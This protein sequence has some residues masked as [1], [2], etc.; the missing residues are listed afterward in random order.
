MTMNLDVSV[1]L[2][3][4]LSRPGRDATAALER[5]GATASRLASRFSP[6]ATGLRGL[7]SAVRDLAAADRALNA[8]AGSTARLRGTMAALGPAGR[9]AASGMAPAI[10]AFDKLALSSTKAANATTRLHGALGAA[11]PAS[12]FVAGAEAQ[13]QTLLASQRAAIANMRTLTAGGGGGG[14]GRGGRRGMGSGSGHGGGAIPGLMLGLQPSGR[15]TLRSV[16]EQATGLQDAIAKMHLNGLSD[17]EI[18]RVRAKAEEVAAMNKSTTPLANIGAIMEARLALGG[19]LNEAISTAGEMSKLRTIV[20]FSLGKDRAKA[21]ED[22]VYDM[23]RTAEVRNVV[24]DPARRDALFKGMTAALIASNGRI[25]PKQWHST[26]IYGRSATQGLSDEFQNYRLPFLMQEL[27]NGG[28]GG[29]AGTALQALFRAIP[30]A[31]QKVSNIPEWRKLGM[32]DE[33]KVI[34]GK[35]GEDKGL[36]PSAI[37]GSELEGTDPD[38]FVY[39]LMDNMAKIG[40]KERGPIIQEFAHLVGTGTGQ[41]AVDVLGLQRARMDNFER[42]LKQVE[43]TA[44]LF[45]QI[46]ETAS[47]SVV[48]LHAQMDALK[49]NIGS[50]VIPA[51]TGMVDAA[52][53][54]VGVASTAASVAGHNGNDPT[55]PGSGYGGKVGALI[56]GGLIW[57]ATKLAARFPWIARIAAGA[58]GTAATQS[59]WGALLGPTLLSG[60]TRAGAL[61]SRYGGVALGAAVV[62]SPLGPAMALKTWQDR[63]D[64]TPE[65]VKRRKDV[66][67][68]LAK[69]GR[70][71]PLYGRFIAGKREAGGPV[72]RGLTYLVG[73]RGPELFTPGESGGITTNRAT[74]GLM[75]GA[76]SGDGET[77]RAIRHL[78]FELVSAVDGIARSLD[79]LSRGRLGDTSDG[80]G[81]GAGSGGGSSSAGGRRGF[82]ARGGHFGGGR[83]AFAARLGLDNGHGVGGHE[84]SGP[85]VALGQMRAGG[86]GA[87]GKFDSKAPAIMAGL[88]QKYGLTHEQ[89]AG[90]V[91]NLGHESARFTAYHEGGQAAGR[92]GVGWAQW[93]GSRRR[94]FEKW[95]KAHGLSPTSD[96]A[97]WRFLTEGDR[98]T[99]GAMAAVKRTHSAAEA[100]RA[101]HDHFERSADISHGR[102]VKQ[103]SWNSRLGLAHRAEG[104]NGRVDGPALADKPGTSAV[105][106]SVADRARRQGD[107]DRALSTGRAKE[108]GGSS[109]GTTNHVTI[110]VHA[111][112]HHDSKQIASMVHERFN[113][114]VGSQLSDGAY[115]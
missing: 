7:S 93:T 62:E 49:G 79:R 61:A 17:G 103:V 15:E 33:S 54:F 84:T 38:K 37:K 94:D 97:S 9:S 25:T 46:N 63:Q 58:A 111:H 43:D 89:A 86:K 69:A 88:M 4:N 77:P 82:M 1:R 92:G 110:A 112:P 109:N 115:G 104:L 55:Q 108:A 73:E 91:G 48:N 22:G 76:G 75:A 59:P 19:D 51:F 29:P 45:K 102:I 90:V 85:R 87:Y 114:A 28:K 53:R 18:A 64:A 30:L 83:R 81:H 60:A 5:M 99:A 100:V 41:T 70:D 96:E 23:L 16:Y 106:E 57:G 40:I 36:L 39:L 2:I 71:S 101:F 11:L 44:T 42:T 10:R 95:T 8:S 47:Q 31:I 66:E 56:G 13:M 3:D 34:K 52:S 26:A 98:E 20:G 50:S 80:T 12:G 21:A 105:P 107:R 27:Q 14:G 32:L 24:K 74:R 113:D 78:S 67:D 65:A 6:L 68:S 72:G 35:H